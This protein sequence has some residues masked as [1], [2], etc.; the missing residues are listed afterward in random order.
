MRAV[1]GVGALRRNAVDIFGSFTRSVLFLKNS[2]STSLRMDFEVAESELTTDRSIPNTSSSG[3]SNTTSR[4]KIA[5]RS[6]V[7]NAMSAETVSKAM[8]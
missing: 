4:V 6:S 8:A 1:S 2:S 7:G 5:R 3:R